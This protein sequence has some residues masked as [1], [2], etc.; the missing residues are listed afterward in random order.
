MQRQSRV[1]N[2]WVPAALATVAVIVVAAV[3]VIA[4][5]A[6]T[7]DPA[8]DGDPRIPVGKAIEVGR[9]FGV[10]G[11]MAPGQELIDAF[12]TI[13]NVSP[14]K[15]R[16]ETI[17]PITG[18]GIPANGQVVDVFLIELPFEATIYHTLPPVQFLRGECVVSETHRVDGFVLEPGD[19]VLIAMHI[20]AHERGTFQIEARDIIYEQNGETYQQRD[21]YSFTGEVRPVWERELN[22]AERRCRGAELLPG[23]G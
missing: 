8:D 13:K 2:K 18:A 3:L 14:D 5:V 16:L 12:A 6:M 10:T 17:R 23:G 15:V 19:E 9:K 22:V 4:W 1:E 21:P 20:A 7:D 11:P